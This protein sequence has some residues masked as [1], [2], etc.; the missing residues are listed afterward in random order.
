MN[1]TQ[2]S[3][4]NKI[5]LIGIL[6]LVSFL[7]FK[8]IEKP[9][10]S[11]SN[12][13]YKHF[14]LIFIIL[15]LITVSFLISFIFSNKSFLLSKDKRVVNQLN[16]NFIWDNKFYLDEF[17]KEI[18]KYDS[19][20]YSE[21]NKK[22]FLI[23]GNSY[24][25]DF[26]L[27][28]KRNQNLFNEYNF[29][30]INNQFYCLKYLSQKIN[31]CGLDNLETIKK[32]QSAEKIFISTRWI[33]KDLENFDEIIKII[34]EYNKNIVLVTRY[35][36][37]VEDQFTLIDIFTLKENRMPSKIEILDLGNQYFNKITINSRRIRSFL[38]SGSV[39]ND[40]DVFHFS[41]LQCDNKK[42]FCNLLSDQNDKIYYDRGHLTL[43]GID[44]Y[45]KE[46]KDKF[47]F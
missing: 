24:G 13:I 6:F 29:S 1:L 9:F 11:K 15:S 8:F 4:F 5:L 46:L 18:K 28:F 36:F 25:A 27:I 38:I 37:L 42:K 16:E 39:K 23:Y 43:D 21:N 26:F 47:I 12:Y 31:N 14:N 10:R 19:F 20:E 40:I 41:D 2:G 22:K 34:K 45:S 44:F 30:Y 17:N 33:Y 3:N 35:E 32:I 7:S